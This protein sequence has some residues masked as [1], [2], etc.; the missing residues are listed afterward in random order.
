MRVIPHP[1]AEVCVFSDT[2]G[3]RQAA[4]DEFQRAAVAAVAARGRFM[5]ALAG[6]STPRGVY[7]A[8]VAHTAAG[9]RA[10]P[11]EAVQVFF[12]DE[13]AV[14]PDHPDSN[15]RLAYETLLKRVPV[16]PANIH[17]MVA[18]RPAWVAADLYEGE[19]RRCF[20]LERNQRPR[21][22]LIM[23]GMGDDGHTASLFPGAPALREEHRLVT[24]TQHPQGGAERITLTLPVLNQASQVMFVV[25][26]PAK[27]GRVREVLFGPERGQALPAQRVRP[28]R[29]RLV[30]L[31]DEAA[32]AGLPGA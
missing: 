18:E 6:G 10:V 3:L 21:F 12:G 29:G 11:W 22:D 9:P 19:L 2:D 25:S 16:S 28:A 17:R 32:A 14:P 13:R 31:L 4:A 23:L 7:S 27:A 5:V 24:V 15:F 8:L 20:Q 30:W 1:R 26:G